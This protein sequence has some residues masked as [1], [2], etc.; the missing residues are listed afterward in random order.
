MNSVIHLEN[1]ASSRLSKHEGEPG[2][3]APNASATNDKHP[4][5]LAETEKLKLDAESIQKLNEG[6]CPE[7][8]GRDFGRIVASL[9]LARVFG[10]CVGTDFH[11][12]IVGTFVGTPARKPWESKVSIHLQRVG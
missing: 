7:G 3:T 12:L 4:A 8:W 11:L 10:W 6:K 1:R 2:I 5:D 9:L